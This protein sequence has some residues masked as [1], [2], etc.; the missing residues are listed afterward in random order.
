[1][2]LVFDTLQVEPVWT[3]PL[4]TSLLS[5]HKTIKTDP[6][7]SLLIWNAKCLIECLLNELIYANDLIIRKYFHTHI[8]I[9]FSCFFLSFCFLRFFFFSFH[10]NLLLNGDDFVASYRVSYCYVLLTYCFIV[11]VCVG[12]GGG[13]LE[14]P[15]G[16]GGGHPSPPSS[17][18]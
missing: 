7:S 12:E 3:D 17:T 9:Q 11:N 5:Y 8:C 16:C 10:W 6:S 4:L 18:V 15:I 1:M 2:V 14:P 13:D